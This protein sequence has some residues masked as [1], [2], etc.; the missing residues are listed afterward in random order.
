MSDEEI[1]KMLFAREESSIKAI[2]LTYGAQCR[3]IAKSILGNEQD[4]EE[5]VNDTYLAIW[6]AV[7]PAK[8]APFSSYLFRIL[9]NLSLKKY[10]SNTAQK[11][12]CVFEEL[13]AELEEYLPSAERACAGYRGFP[14]NPHA[15][16]P[17]GFYAPILVFR[18]L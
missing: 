2:D 15:R 13:L 1:V 8:P 14:G 7:P 11:R 10:D 6:N 9:R 3:I 17:Q 16:K 18:K 4:A 12:N 5:C